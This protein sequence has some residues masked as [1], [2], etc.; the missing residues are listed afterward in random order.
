MEFRDAC[1][2]ST[3]TGKDG[4]E[5][6]TW[7]RIGRLVVDGDKMTMFTPVIASPVCFFK[8]KSKEEQQQQNA[9]QF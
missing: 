7:F 1:V 3:Y 2:G 4:E 5:K 6:T 9:D 8:Q